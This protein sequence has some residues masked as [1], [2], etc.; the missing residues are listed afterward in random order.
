MARLNQWLAGRGV[1][2]EM[3]PAAEKFLL[4]R[5]KNDLRLGARDLVRAHRR[6]VEFPLGDLLV[7]QRLHPGGV[8]VV[9]RKEGQEHLDF[10]VTPDQMAPQLQD[11]REVPVVWEGEATP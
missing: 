11:P 10:T 3:R 2:C 1:R 8:V 5:G 6:Y 4:Q 9:D 7:S